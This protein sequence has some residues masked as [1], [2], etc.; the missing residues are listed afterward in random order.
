MTRQWPGK[1]TAIPILGMKGQQTFNGDK[2]LMYAAREKQARILPRGQRQR[3]LIVAIKD[4]TFSLGTF[5]NPVKVSNLL[6]S[7]AIMSIRIFP[8]MT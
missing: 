2:A 1:T 7:L 4:K 8:W 3:Q 5:S 6:S